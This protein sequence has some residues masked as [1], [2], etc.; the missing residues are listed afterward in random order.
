MSVVLG[1]AAPQRPSRRE[2]AI[3]AALIALLALIAAAVLQEQ[4]RP[5]PAV[6]NFLHARALTAAARAPE[7]VA[8]VSPPEGTRALTAPERFNRETL[9]DKI[10]GKAELYLAAGFVRLDCQRLALEGEDDAWI[11]VFLYEMGSFENAFSVFSAQ[12]RPDAAALDVAEF[13]YAAE[14]A[15]FFVHGTRYVELIASGTGEPFTQAMRA[16]AQGLI[17]EHPA[18]RPALTERE[19]FPAEGLLP[20]SLGRVAADAFGLAGLDRVYRAT[21]RT[22]RGEAMLFFTRRESAEEAQALARAYLAML[23]AFGAAI[24]PAEGLEGASRIEVLD[25]FEIVFTRGN[26]F[27]GVREADDPRLALDLARRLD[28]RLAEAGHALR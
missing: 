22:E 5:H 11:E 24:A 17:A 14:N 6:E 16:I 25:T 18:A 4:K 1:P 19:L 13:A 12:R 10:D 20:E 27:A 28:E 23:R 3:A 7:P 2:S 8:L 15:F 9:S 21:Y 26:F